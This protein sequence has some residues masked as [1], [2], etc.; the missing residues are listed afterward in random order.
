M[1]GRIRWDRS[2]ALR[3][4]ICALPGAVVAALWSVPFG[5]A[6]ALGT[7]IVALLGVPPREQGRSR[8]LT[9][10]L[11]F[12]GAYA[13]GAVIVS[14]GVIAVA[15]LAAACYACVLLA[16]RGGLGRVVGSFAAPALALGMNHPAPDGFLLAGTFVVGSLW[17]TLV[18]VIWPDRFS[19]TPA[20]RPPAG[21]TID[22]RTYAVSFALAGA[23]GLVIG[24][25]LDLV[26]VA[27]SAGAALLIMRPAPGQ[28]RGRAVQRIVATFAGITLAVGIAAFGPSDLAIAVVVALAIAG[29]VATRGSDWYVTS[30]GTGL[31]GLLLSSLSGTD[32]LTSTYQERLLETAIGAALAI[33][34]GLVVPE[35]IARR[36]R[37]RSFDKP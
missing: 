17:A 4:L 26:H 18:T 28:T 1:G 20:P 6:L 21:P 34:F 5:G 10:G 36:S 13:V 23:I 12:A 22:V 2:D 7:I 31:I 29:V 30:A 16:T 15:G 3:G 27:W 14:N 11:V 33:L 32:A 24:L 25:W 37:A 9:A 8:V 35:L 19:T